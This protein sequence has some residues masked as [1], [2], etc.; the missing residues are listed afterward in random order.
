M[1]RYYDIYL[2]YL[3]LEYDLVMTVYYF[4]NTIQVGILLQQV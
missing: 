1:N 3:E 4:I 2:R